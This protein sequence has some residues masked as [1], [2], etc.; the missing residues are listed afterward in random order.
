MRFSYVIILRIGVVRDKKRQGWDEMIDY[1][2]LLDH[3]SLLEAELMGLCWNQR[4]A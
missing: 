2:R 1:K 3:P 4:S